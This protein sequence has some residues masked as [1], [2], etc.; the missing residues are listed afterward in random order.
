MGGQQPAHQLPRAAHRNARV[1]A[2]L[3]R[4]GHELFNPVHLGQ[5]VWHSKATEQLLVQGLG[6]SAVLGTHDDTRLQ[7]IPSQP[8]HDK[9]LALADT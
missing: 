4:D 8:I 3:Q 6:R 7:R 5:V 9:I 2:V 1:L